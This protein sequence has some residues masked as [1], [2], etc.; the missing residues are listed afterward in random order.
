ALGGCGSD[1]GPGA[2]GALPTGYCC[3]GDGECRGRRC[4]PLPAGGSA[5]A[6]FCAGD[7]DCTG[8]SG[9]FRCDPIL[10]YCV[11]SRNDVPCLAAAGFHAGSLEIGACCEAGPRAGNMC[12]GGLC[13]AHGPGT[14]YYCTQGCDGNAP[15]P[16]GY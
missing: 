6:D 11:P 7:G 5:C 16:G 4:L 8:W 14:P 13:V 2:L 1:G 15:C 9:E 3:A 12:R 10:R